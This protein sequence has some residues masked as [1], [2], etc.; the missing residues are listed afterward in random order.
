MCEII[1]YF[2]CSKCGAKFPTESI[3]RRH[4]CSAKVEQ[5]ADNTAIPKLPTDLGIT[6]PCYYCIHREGCDTY[7]KFCESSFYTFSGRQ[8]RA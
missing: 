4:K 2:E 5:Q 8:L 3:A 7:G 1:E 6:T